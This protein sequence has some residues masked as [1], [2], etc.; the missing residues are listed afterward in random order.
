MRYVEERSR[1]VNSWSHGHHHHHHHHKKNE[2]LENVNNDDE[3]K[4]TS[5]TTSDESL[6]TQTQDESSLLRKVNYL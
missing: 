2:I 6:K 3:D 4:N 1:G 5:E